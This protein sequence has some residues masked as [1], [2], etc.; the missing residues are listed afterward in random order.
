MEKEV[1]DAAMFSAG[2]KTTYAGAGS[3]GL[4]WLLS[5]EAAV[6]YGIVVGLVGIAMQLIFGIRKDRRDATAHRATMLEHE[7]RMGLLESGKLTRD[8]DGS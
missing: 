5:S 7:R 4:G 3:L 1:L 6:V 2:T 8:E